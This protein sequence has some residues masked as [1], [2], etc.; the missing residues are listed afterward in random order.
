MTARD[1]F[2]SMGS[3]IRLSLSPESM[4]PSFAKIA[5]GLHT[6]SYVSLPLGRDL[7]KYLENFDL[8][9][10]LRSADVAWRTP[11]QAT[12][13]A[14]FGRESVFHGPRD[15]TLADAAAALHD[16]LAMPRAGEAPGLA[17]PAFFGGARFAAGGRR[18]RAWDAFGGWGFVL[19]RV[20]LALRGGIVEGSVT[21]LLAP[22]TT[23]AEITARLSE[24][25]VDDAQSACHSM[26]CSG[27]SQEQYTAA[28][29]SALEEIRRQQYDKVVLA[30]MMAIHGGGVDDGRVLARLL[31]RYNGCYVFKMAAGDSAWVGASPELLCEAKDGIFRTAAL[32]GSAPRGTDAEADDALAAGL[33]GDAKEQREHALVVE[34]LRCG[35]EPYCDGLSAQAA[36]EILRNATIQHLRTP[37]EGRLR[38]GANLLAV[39]GTLHPS[40]AVGGTPRPIALDAIRRLEG[41]DRGWYAGPIGRLGF[42]GDGEFAVGTTLRADSRRCGPALCRRGDRLREQPGPRIRRD[43]HQAAPAARGHP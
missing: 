10:V 3:R 6:P 28:V 21:L 17:Q 19:P 40:P 33:I 42:D 8:E 9:A 29:A 15:S 34:A 32:A 26:P 25:L 2:L 22:G 11:G 43:Q 27:T 1:T 16:P 31:D 23:E 37:I 13:L 18:D 12:L 5:S 30:R 38:P 24:P 4:A 36:P 39:L 20:L 41:M 7:C 14:G 35:L